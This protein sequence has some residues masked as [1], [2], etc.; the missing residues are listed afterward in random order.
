MESSAFQHW[1]AIWIAGT[2]PTLFCCAFEKPSPQEVKSV[3]NAGCNTIVVL[4]VILFNIW[5]QCNSELSTMS[6]NW[7]RMVKEF[8][9]SKTCFI[10][11]MWY[12]V[13]QITATAETVK[14]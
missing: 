3:L 14:I 12:G 8:E 13:Y 4:V 5:N 6:G 2:V 10:K 11:I 1:F 9:F 7:V